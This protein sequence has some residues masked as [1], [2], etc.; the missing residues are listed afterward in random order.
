MQDANSMTGWTER[1]LEDL[2]K[3][4]PR[5]L[6]L[7]DRSVPLWAVVLSMLF[8]G[9]ASACFVTLLVLIAFYQDLVTSQG[10][11][12]MAYLLTLGAIVPVLGILVFE[13]GHNKALAGYR[14][15]RE[16]NAAFGHALVATLVTGGLGFLD[17]L[18]LI[19]FVGGAA[20]SWLVVFPI[21]RRLPAE[22]LWEFVPT[23]AVSF[24][25]GRDRR[26]V[27]LANSPADSDAP[28][29][30]MLRAVQ[31]MALM[32]TVAIC[33]W[34]AAREV[35]NGAAVASIAFLNFWSTHTFSR[36]FLRLSKNDPEN[37]GRAANV[38][39]LPDPEASDG[40]FSDGLTVRNL[41]VTTA[42]GQPLLSDVSFDVAPGTI[43]GLCGDEFAGKSLLMQA[44][45]AP[46]DLKGLSVSGFVS[47]AGDTPWIRSDQDRNISS[48]FVP[49]EPLTVPGCGIDNLSC[50]SDDQDSARARRNLKSLVHN[51]DT[52][53][54]IC[55]S[56]DIRTLSGTDK[57]A[58]A[59]ARALFL[60]PRLFLLDRP[61]DG[62]SNALL[63]ALSDRLKEESRLGG[64]FVVAT[65]NR[66]ILDACDKLLMLQNGR[67][68]ELAP[69]SEINARRF[70]GWIRFVCERDPDSE[71]ALDSWIRS[72][73]RRDGDEANRRNVCMIA[74]EMLALSC[75]HRKD[76]EF[77]TSVSFE[78]QH[79][80]GYCTLRTLENSA[81]VSSATLEKARKELEQHQD[82][83]AMSPLAKVMKYAKSVEITEADGK[84]LLQVT[85]VTY[86]PRQAQ[87][88]KAGHHE[89]Q[90]G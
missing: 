5:P 76:V 30:S 71:D 17:P 16:R 10:Q 87:S 1:A 39:A 64:I 24:L 74:N 38:V 21:G 29:N 68:I 58:L 26:A 77:G 6:P 11:E 43:I 52:V 34:L 73:F 45:S 13:I 50:F 88:Q 82:G 14:H 69:A 18:L 3:S 25:S 40:E 56:S 33:S 59:F 65:E 85:V 79:Q 55:H 90:T 51:S 86:D 48:I 46:H 63:R 37:V 67:V 49:P 9:G 19:S 36:F 61:E 75:Q 2:S 20:L 81:I 42:S 7:Q 28:V 12:I 72:Q 22:R 8:S 66:Q 80:K 89:K 62:A 44:L 57:K 84:H 83:T 27:E 47:I 78:F 4:D 35:L 53:E 32:V 15:V 60:R 70:A 31:A 41:N 23:E 54:H